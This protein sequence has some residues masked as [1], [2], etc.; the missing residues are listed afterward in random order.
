MIAWFAQH[1]TA[2]NVFMAAFLIAGLMTVPRLQRETFPAVHNDKVAVRVVYKGATTKDVE[3]AVCRRLEDALDSITDLD[4][5]RCDAR[6]GLGTATAVMREGA[7]MS[8]FLDDVKS[9]VDTINNF[10]AQTEPPV[11]EEIGRTDAVISV[12]ITGPSDPVVLKAYAEDVKTR[13]RALGEVASVEIDGF[14]AHQIRV[15]VPAWRLRQY[16]LSA[17]DIATAVQNQSV[18]SP[19]GRLEGTRE[20][21]PV[22]L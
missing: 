16:G 8:R 5:V 19:A 17:A 15:E 2:A 9:A 12:A 3:D 11:V 1:P 6:E 21:I 13:I 4:E 22:A 14:A 18:A 20:D 7:D 10:P